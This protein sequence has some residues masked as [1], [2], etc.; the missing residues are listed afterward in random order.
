MDEYIFKG[1]IVSWGTNSFKVTKQ[2]WINA[3][4]LNNIRNIRREIKEGNENNGGTDQEIIYVVGKNL[5]YA[6]N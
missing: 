1:F 2:R 4:M 5:S 3:N 6:E